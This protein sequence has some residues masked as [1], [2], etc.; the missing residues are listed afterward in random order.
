M[1]PQNLMI[2]FDGWTKIVD[3]GLVKATGK[4]HTQTGHLR[5]KLAYM[6]PE[7]A[8][9]KPITATADLFALGVVFWELLTGKRLFAGESDAE[10]LDRV[11]RCELPPLRTHRD[12][13]PP[14]IEPILRRALAREPA[15]R[16]TS[17]DAMLADLRRSLRD[18]L[19]P[20]DPRKQLAAIMRQHFEEQHKYRIAALRGASRGAG[21][22]RMHLVQRTPSA[23]QPAIE[24]SNHDSSLTLVAANDDDTR[25]PEDGLAPAEP[26]R[27][28]SGGNLVVA[29]GIEDS[30][31]RTL[32]QGPGRHWLWWLVLPMFGATLAVAILLTVFN[33]RDDA[34]RD[35]L[36]DAF[37]PETPIPS[38]TPPGPS[39]EPPAQPARI[40]WNLESEPPGA[41]VSI[42]G[43]PPAV[44]AE[45][46][47]QLAGQVTP[48]QHRDPLRRTQ[49]RRGP[50]HPARLQGQPPQPDADQQREHQRQP[51]GRP[52]RHPRARHQ[53]QEPQARTLPARPAKAQPARD[54][55]RR[56]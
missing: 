1:S 38:V 17:A 37:R 50:V 5:G 15:D 41:Q 53:A 21:R 12:D 30:A 26:R 43:A 23:S 11:V 28:V 25:T 52:L 22:P 39:R 14:D 48:P 47:R 42:L 56:R 2:G 35:R 33:W 13:L 4:R 8:R 20:E 31:A 27:P 9:G 18:H 55:H 19:G 29:A 45:L 6:S 40:V 24:R 3:F 7:Q 10:T 16:Y 46:E 51:A 49:P 34:G 54:L 32:S 36:T 44:A